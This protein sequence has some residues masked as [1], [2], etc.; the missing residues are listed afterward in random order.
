MAKG[1]LDINKNTI[2]ITTILYVWRKYTKT[3]VKTA[4]VL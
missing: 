4:R 1:W 2:K 3:P